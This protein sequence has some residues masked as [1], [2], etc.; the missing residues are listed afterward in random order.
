MQA[1]KNPKEIK[2]AQ[3]DDP[4]K[5]PEEYAVRYVARSIRNSPNKSWISTVLHGIYINKGGTETNKS[6][7]ITKITEYM[8]NEIYV[9]SSPGIASIIMPKDKASLMFKLQ[10]EVNDDDDTVIRQI[11]QRIKSELKDLP[12]NNKEY[13]SLDKNNL[14]DECS[15]TLL[16]LLYSISPNFKNSLAAAMIGNIVTGT[17]N[18]NY[19]RLQ[20]SMGILAHDKKLIEHLH[21]YGV[22]CTHHEVR[23]FKISAAVPSEN[24]SFDKQISSS[25]GLIQVISDNFDAHIHSQHELKETHSLATMITQ[26]TIDV[27]VRTPIPRLKQEHLKSVKLNEPTIRFYTG[28]K[29]PPMPISFCTSSVLPLKILANQ[30]VSLLKSKKTDFNF[31]KST[32]SNESIPDYN[33]YNTGQARITDMSIKPK[34]QVMFQP[35]IDKVPSDPSTILTAMHEAERITIDAG[36]CVTVFTADQQLYRVAL[37]IVWSEPERWRNFY[38]RIGGMHWL[39]SFIGCV[40]VLMENSGLTPWL[41]SSFAGAEKMLIGKK[42]PQN[43]RA[44]RFIVELLKDFVDDLSS[45][46]ELQAMLDDLAAKRILSKHWIENLIKPVFLT[47]LYIRAEREGNFAL[48]L[49]SCQLMLPYFFAAG[50]FNYA[51]YGVCYMLTMSRLPPA[52]LEQFIKGEHVLHH[53]FG[54]WNGIWSDMMIETTYMKFGKGPSG[55]I[56]QTTKPR[57]VQIWAKSQHSCGKVL[58]ELSTTLGKDDEEKVSH[59]EG[60]GRMK[61]DE[62]D[63]KMLRDFFGNCIH[64]L[65]LNSHDQTVLCNIYTGQTAY[66]TVNVYDSVKIGENQ[67]I[68]F[69]RNLPEGFR[70]TISKTVVTMKEGEKSKKKNIVE[71]YNTETIFSH[72]IY[73]LSASH[74]DIGDLFT[75]ELS[76]VP[77]SLFKDTGEGRYP[78]AKSVLKNDLKVE[79]T[80]RNLQCDAV[81]IDGCAML[82]SVI[83]WPKGGRVD[84]LVQ[85]VSIKESVKRHTDIIPSL[86]SMHALTG[87]DTVPMMF[88]IGKKKG[89]GISNK[90]PLLHLGAADANPKQIMIEA[91]ESV[92]NCY[93]C[94]SESSSKNR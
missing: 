52:V 39:M 18:R 37:D 29:N 83:H 43:I 3:H 84:D 54:L 36:Q 13:T 87:C 22:T 53:R 51:R 10:T 91:K 55:I 69:K 59:K 64:P 70:S 50:H 67:L 9:F 90:L 14:F 93:G 76:P 24:P 20:L 72:V 23:R 19:T 8:K 34:S 11:A 33:G 25:N 63:R 89:I 38:P 66:E 82:H 48:H 88:G 60:K 4:L 80:M 77:I 44:L 81:I 2:N 21:N 16:N 49:Y 27:S 41:K 74:I 26:P 31:I 61:S 46:E 28:Q 68:E 7:F 62:V 5:S 40:G 17:A 57:T 47:M 85:S 75:F 42:F 78:T 32:I 12:N 73:L 58:K 6:R 79:V 94:K 92:A 65:H 30:I 35:L 86:L 71:V 1:F 56:G 15:K 45:Y